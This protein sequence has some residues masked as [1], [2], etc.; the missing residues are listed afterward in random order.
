MP[1]LRAIDSGNNVILVGTF[2]K[3]LCRS[4]ALGYV[5]LPPVLLDPFLVLRYAADLGTVGF[6][7]RCLPIS[8]MRATWGVILGTCGRSMARG[9]LPC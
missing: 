3:L 6:S 2:N 4:I 7:R 5:V 1:T 9:S 8:F